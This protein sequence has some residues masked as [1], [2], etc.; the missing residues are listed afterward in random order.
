MKLPASPGCSA[1]DRGGGGWCDDVAHWRGMPFGGTG[2]NKFFSKYKKITFVLLVAVLAFVSLSS[3]ALADTDAAPMKQLQALADKGDA[4]AQF[5]LCEKYFD[6]DEVEQDYSRAA[7]Y[8]QKSA[9]Q[10][11]P[12]AEIYLGW[13]YRKGRGVARDDKLAFKWLSKSAARG[14]TD[15]QAAI[16]AMYAEGAGVKRDFVQAYKWANIAENTLDGDDETAA[17]LSDA[18]RY[19]A[20][21]MPP[22]DVKMAQQQAQD[23]IAA[24]PPEVK[25]RTPPKLFFAIFLLPAFLLASL[26]GRQRR[27]HLYYRL[28]T[29]VAVTAVMFMPLFLVLL[30]NPNPPMND[31]ALIRALT[32]AA[33]FCALLSYAARR[34][35]TEGLSYFDGLMFTAASVTGLWGTARV[36]VGVPL[37]VLVIVA[38]LLLCLFNDLTGRQ[39]RTP[40]QFQKLIG[41][42]YKNR[43]MQ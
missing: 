40:E 1:V 13:M 41:R 17:D 21:K 4:D 42:I 26:P 20:K 34:S 30:D 22:A 6:G 25:Y 38:S 23:W 16:G 35:G 11:N 14:N 43:M 8:C 9:A 10:D 33:G 24:H 39:Q 36:V 32:W 28:F 3:F 31:P 2:M 29:W 5:R 27:F 19:L 18:M 37:V 12:D 15:A 7:S